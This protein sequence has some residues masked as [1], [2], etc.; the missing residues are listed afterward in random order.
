MKIAHVNAAFQ[1]LHRRFG[2]SETALY[3]TLAMTRE[4][5]HEVF[6]VTLRPDVEQ[7]KCDFPF[8]TLRRCEDYLPSLLARYVEPVKWYAWQ[9]DPLAAADFRAVMRKEKPDIVHFHNFQFCGL[10]LVRIASEMGAKTCYSVY[11][12]WIFCPNV[13]LL[14]G[15]E[16]YCRRFHGKHCAE[17]LPNFLR[18]FQRLLLAKRKKIFDFYM[19]FIDRWIVLSNHS[20]TVLEDYGVPR[21]K[22]KMVRL[23]LPFEFADISDQTSGVID[24]NMIFFAGWLQ[25]RKGVHVLLEA[26]PLIRKQCPHAKLRIAGHKT[27]FDWDYKKKIDALMQKPGMN[28]CVTFLGQ[29]SS[30]QIADELRRCSVVAVPEQYENM[31]PIIMIE[32]MTLEKPVVISRAGGIPEYIEEGK[33][34][35]MAGPRNVREFAD[36]ISAVLLGKVDAAAVGK[37]ARAKIM[38]ICSKE[39]I[40]AA[41]MAAYDFN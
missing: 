21:K 37:R 29:L 3:R 32:A 31:S 6:L 11:D 26:M 39:N 23:S 9:N 34:G 28:E 1:G 19:R 18:P 7:P 33:T 4:Q 14:D 5:G 16:Q 24:Q 25:Q 41:T 15:R 40:T 17:C 10:E 12:Y 38:E 2:G 22:I 8:Y 35:W 36:K 20:V 13:M 30:D 27:K